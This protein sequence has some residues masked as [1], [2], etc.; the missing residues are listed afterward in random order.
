MNEKRYLILAGGLWGVSKQLFNGRQID[1]EAGQEKMCDYVIAIKGLPDNMFQPEELN[2]HRVWKCEHCNRPISESEMEGKWG[3]FA[4]KKSFTEIVRDKW[5]VDVFEKYSIPRKK[6][7]NPC[8]RVWLNNEQGMEKFREI[9]RYVD[10]N[11]PSNKTMPMPK[12][13]GNKIQWL[14]EES[15]VPFIDL[16]EQEVPDK[17]E[18]APEVRVEKKEVKSYICEICDK[19]W[20]NKNSLRIH[21]MHCLKRKKVKVEV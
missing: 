12:V 18:P 5:R 16:S 20:D 19:E 7:M 6:W 13:V 2:R 17:V 1:P 15:E 10:R 11:F 3:C 8:Y 4:H 9:W 21:K 14:V